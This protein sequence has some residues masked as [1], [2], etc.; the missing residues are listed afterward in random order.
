MT[1]ASAIVDLDAISAN[2]ARVRER[3]RGAEVMGVVKADAYGHGLTRVAEHLRAQDVGWLGVALPGEALTLRAAGDRGRILSWLWAPG[4]VDAAACVAADVDLSV[5]SGWALEEVVGAARASGRVA[6]VHLKVD[7]GLSRNG[8][9]P[10]EWPV[11]A[12][13]AAR[14]QAAGDIVVEAVWS[15]LAEGESAAADSVAAQGRAFDAAWE[16]ATA[17]GLG[18]VRRHVSNSGA[19]FANPALHFDLVRAGIALYG[20][21]PSDAL[22]TSR[23]LGLRPALTLRARVANV[24]RVAAGSGVSYGHTWS[25]PRDTT[26]ALVPV[27][28]ADGVPRSAGGRAAIAVGGTRYPIVGRVAM[29]QVVIDVGDDVV[30]VGQEATLFGPGDAGEA[31]AD[32]W[33]AALGTIGYEIVTRLGSRVRREHR[34]GTT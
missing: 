12:A 3:A 31:T 2:L 29:D 32:E 19:V 28:Y 14:A 6:R 21:T 9:A 24:K 10:A 18:G 34:G 1:S 17:V 33:A 20:L 23:G 22:G 26:L 30:R 5:S 27:G 13:A 25:A 4:D 7:T 8:V 15:H 16:V 11:I